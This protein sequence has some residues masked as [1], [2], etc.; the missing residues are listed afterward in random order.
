M[1]NLQT[2]VPVFGASDV[3]EPLHRLADQLKAQPAFTR[4]FDAYRAMQADA[5]A[6]SLLAELQARQY[7]G[8]GEADYDRLLLQFYSRPSVKA[9]QA[10]EEKLYDLLQTIDAVIS[11]ASSIDFAAN[12]KRSCCG[13]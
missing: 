8:M 7:Q 11:E 10:A 6:Q 13:G 9:Y 2:E 12:A 1:I 3:S 4:F 5:E